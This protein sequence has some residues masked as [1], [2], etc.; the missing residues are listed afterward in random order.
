M[1]LLACA[2]CAAYQIGARTL[3]APDIETVY[4]PMVENNTFRRYLGE[5][6]T[7]A[8]VKEIELKTPYKV[9]NS[10]TADSVLSV[11]LVAE[12]KKVVVET[13]TDE[14]RELQVEFH[15]IV[16][17]VD[18]HGDVVQPMQPVPLPAPFLDVG[19]TA[20]LVPEV[21]QS[22]A[23]SQQEAIER[24]AEQIVSLMEAPW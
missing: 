21:G 9:V 24:L 5:R 14:G 7:E 20:N 4:V 23:S 15:A 1:Y 12:G 6:L 19:Q 17:W 13:P 8:I 3:Y 11:R 16:T 2:G 18:R 10:P 22:V